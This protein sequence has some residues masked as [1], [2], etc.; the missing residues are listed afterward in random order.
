MLVTSAEILALPEVWETYAL[1]EP[2]QYS[3]DLR[4]RGTPPTNTPPANPVFTQLQ[5]FGG[6]LSCIKGG[7]SMPSQSYD[8]FRRD[9]GGDPVWVEAARDVETAK[10]RI[11]ELSAS[12]PG[13]YVVFSQR[14]GR[15]VSS[16]TVVASPAARAT[17]KER[18]HAC[19]ESVA[20]DSDTPWK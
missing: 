14:S 7:D 8:I 4:F 3:I 19:A 11:I 1:L 2:M 13:T 16:G 6:P 20:R 17:D 18:L 10:S 12:A 5:E 9:A 15:M